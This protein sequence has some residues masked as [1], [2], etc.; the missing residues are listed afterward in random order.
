M[1]NHC[2]VYPTICTRVDLTIAK[3]ELL[4][5]AEEGRLLC[6]YVAFSYG[7]QTPPNPCPPNNVS[8]G[9]SY[10]IK[11]VGKGRRHSQ[12]KLLPSALEPFSVKYA[13]ARSFFINSLQKKG[14]TPHPQEQ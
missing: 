6:S 3:V 7:I 2:T 14:D 11:V 13:I 8:V 9:A 10:S 4:K 12:R 1:T 5:K